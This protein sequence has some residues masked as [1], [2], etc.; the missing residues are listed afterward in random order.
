MCAPLSFGVGKHERVFLWGRSSQSTGLVSPFRLVKLHIGGMSKKPTGDAM[1]T[2]PYVKDRETRT[3]HN[4]T[5]PSS[6]SP[7]L[8]LFPLLLLF[9]HAS[10]CSSDS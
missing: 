1:P 5:L 3:I 8:L 7:P 10:V 6:L 9:P 2:L 4:A